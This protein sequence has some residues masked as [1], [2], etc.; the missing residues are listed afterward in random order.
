MD[1]AALTVFLGWTTLIN[2]GF[3]LL[4]ILNITARKNTI[5]NFHAKTFGLKKEDLL[6]GYFQHL[7]RYKNLIIF[8]NLVPY[9]ALR[10][11]H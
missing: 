3:F 6:R 10:L 7:G 11:I 8:F 4:A 1:I 9:L 2:I 5:D